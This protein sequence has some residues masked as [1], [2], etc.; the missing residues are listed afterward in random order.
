MRRVLG[1]HRKLTVIDNFFRN[2]D[3]MSPKPAPCSQSRTRS[4]LV[5]IWTALDQE[6]RPSGKRNVTEQIKKKSYS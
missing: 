2:S 5:R 1:T 4:R 6:N 3:A